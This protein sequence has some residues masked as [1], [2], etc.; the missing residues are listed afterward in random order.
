MTGQIFWECFYVAWKMLV[1]TSLILF[2]FVQNTFKL[3]CGQLFWVIFDKKYTKHLC[4]MCKL[5]LF[6]QN[7][8]WC[9]L[10]KWINSIMI[11][12]IYKIYGCQYFISNSSLYIKLLYETELNWW[13]YGISKFLIRKLETMHQLIMKGHF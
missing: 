2:S 13:L 11:K 4:K 8:F 1:S 10:C 3:Y 7:G 9:M 5:T 6:I 12:I